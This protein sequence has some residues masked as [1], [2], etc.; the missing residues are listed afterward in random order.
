MYYVLVVN[1]GV[2]M[3]FEE[4]EGFFEEVMI[5]LRFEE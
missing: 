2:L 4:L 5:E 3:K 1:N